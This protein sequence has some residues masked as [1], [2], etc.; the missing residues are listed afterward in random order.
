M[1]GKHLLTKGG[2]VAGI[3]VFTVLFVPGISNAQTAS[4]QPQFL[5]TWQALNSYA[6][7]YYQGKV[8]PG[9]S[10]Q[11]VASVELV[12]G[13]KLVNLK[14]Q[15]IYWYLN[16]NY[17]GGG[18]GA[19][20]ITFSPYGGAPDS[21][22]LEVKLPSY[23][24]DSLLHTVSIPVVQ[25]KAVIVARYPQ[26]QFS[27]NPFTLQAQAYFFNVPSLLP[28]VFNWSANNQVANNTENPTEADISIPSDSPSGS[29][30][31]VTLDVK[32]S[33]DS[34]TADDSKILTYQ[35]QLQ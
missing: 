24:N 31:S 8:L 32:N 23:N 29:Q 11:I 3:F 16:T 22:A 15:T 17:I 18:I 4:A 28:L 30:L 2:L 5:V 13:G 10:S 20:R 27:D 34:S 35:K 12:S 6:P 25:P 33:L 7:P 19:Q 21:L 1:M 26:N 9:A 14:N